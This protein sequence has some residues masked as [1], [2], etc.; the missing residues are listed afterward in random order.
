M[1]RRKAT[2]IVE[3]AEEPR[4]RYVITYTPSPTLTRFH[5]SPAF[6]RGILGPVGSGKSSGM[7]TEILKRAQEQAPNRRGKRRTKWAIVRNCYDAKTEI[8]TESRGWV[9]FSDLTVEDKVATLKDNS[10]VFEKPT[11]HYAAPYCGEMIGLRSQ[12]MDLL[13]TPDH[14][15]YVSERHTRNKVWNK[16]HLATAESLYGKGE[17]VRMQ[18]KSGGWLDGHSEHSEAFFE[19]LGFWFAEGS[20]G[21]YVRKRA[22]GSTWTQFSF[23]ISQKKNC[24]YAESVMTNAGFE[25]G[26][27]DKGS[28][29]FNYYISHKS[30]RV[31]NL[32]NELSHCGQATTK[33]LP[34]WIKTA[35]IGHLKAFL[36]GHQAGDGRFKTCAHTCDQHCTSSAQLADDIQELLIKTGKAATKN[37]R[38]TGGMFDITVL[39]PERSNPVIQKRHWYKQVYSGNVYCLEVSTHVILV[40]RNGTVQFSGQTYGQLKDTTIQT[41]LDWF[42]EHAFGRFH[43]TDYEHRIRIGEYEIDVL[44][45]ALDRPDHVA[46]LLSLELTGAWINEAREIPYSIIKATGDRV[47]R[48]PSKKDEGCTWRGVMMDTNPPDSDHWWPTIADRDTSTPY[49]KELISSIEQS[50][51][52]MRAEGLLA[53]DQPMMAFFRQPGG[54][55]ETG[56][57]KDGQPIFVPNPTAENLENLER[58]Y[59]I[60]RMAGASV[61]HIR[62]YYCAQYGFSFDGKP[63]IHEYREQSHC[64]SEK[65]EPIKGI[66][67][68]FG[69]DWGLTP[70]CI[71][72]QRYANGRIVWLDELV[73]EDMGAE[74]F[75]H[76]FVQ[77]VNE[78]FKG[79][80]FAHGT[81]DPAGEQRS[82]T[83]ELTP[84]QI[85]NNVLEKARM[86][87]RCFPAPTNDF[88]MRREAI[89]H[90]L[91]R[92]IDGHPGLLVSPNLTVTRKGLAG[93]Y[94][95]KKMRVS[96]DDRYHEKPDKNKYSHPVEAGGYLNLGIGEGISLVRGEPS[97]ED[98][99]YSYA[100][101][102]GHGR[103]RIC[104]Y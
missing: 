86:P 41:W 9:K 30:D 49:G 64:A 11:M 23:V 51:R 44:F 15:L 62:V 102:T 68:Q 57:D 63:I 72:G 19:F 70:A 87:M 75:A 94:C 95:Y 71:F 52:L 58:G 69:I 73:T 103:S 16:Y 81:A 67:I 99:V 93:G 18:S 29:N 61:Q 34:E 26:K 48:F 42:P 10:L 101:M 85:F 53:E 38:A 13:V 55:L 12:N 45:R 54:L 47:G 80:V 14:H 96:G 65:L 17:T 35:P 37:F 22:V 91:T 31:K 78:R 92:L 76:L 32:I 27:S 3:P 98:E 7:C 4:E 50:E 84:F 20:A 60:S 83:D 82:Q 89:A 2:P 6:Y 33:R 28:G 88:I 46:N 66:P 24:E 39:T 74:R 56:L 100:G 90:P 43:N 97:P 8:L 25:Y 5:L 1:A 77:T 36:K 59:Y 79:H 104:G 40:R 21:V